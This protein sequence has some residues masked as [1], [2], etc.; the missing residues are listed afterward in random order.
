M[1]LSYEKTVNDITRYKICKLLDKNKSTNLRNK[2]SLMRNIL[3]YLIPII[4][5]TT[6]V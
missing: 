1:H 2:I 5:S 3:S 6:D 4:S